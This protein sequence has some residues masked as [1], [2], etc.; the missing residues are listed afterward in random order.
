MYY[1]FN[2]VGLTEN[3]INI[4][5]L[6][7]IKMK[8][9]KIW[10]NVEIVEKLFKIPKIACVYLLFDDWCLEYIG[11]TSNLKN[12]IVNHKTMKHSVLAH[13]SKRFNKVIYFPCKNK[14]QRIKIEDDLIFE[15]EPMYNH[16][17]PLYV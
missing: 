9:T 6:L 8:N 12:R 14:K 4:L 15:Y 1:I 11:Q 17:S 13:G 10:A 16:F 2:R 3:Y 7:V 5:H